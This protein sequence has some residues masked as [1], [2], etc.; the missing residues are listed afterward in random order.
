M[1]RAMRTTLSLLLA[2]GIASCGSKSPAPAAMTRPPADTTAERIAGTGP[3]SEQDFKAM[4]ELRSDAPPVAEGQDIE[5]AGTRAYLSLPKG[6]TAPLPGIV[7]IHEWWGLNDN[8]RHWSDR[9]A[10]L[11]YAALAIDLYGGKVATN[12]DEAMA[13]MK[14]VKSAEA[15]RILAAAVEFL[16]SDPRVKAPKRAVIGWCFGGGWSLETAIDHPELDAAIV[17]YGQL[18]LDPKRL[19]HIKSLLGIFANQDKGIPPDQV[20]Q[21]EQALKKAGVDA[22]I[23]RFDADHAF[24]NPSGPRYDEADAAAAWQEVVTYLRRTMPAT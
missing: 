16:A 14:G 10:H 17:Y 20:N 8:I 18:E 19:G 12:P 24:A 21:F 4:H 15:K 7:V 11:G 6:A 9:L 2:L 22:T 23:K 13:A 5:L 1:V 3:I